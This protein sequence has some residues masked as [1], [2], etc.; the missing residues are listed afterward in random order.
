VN[1]EVDECDQGGHR[2]PSYPILVWDL[3]K[4][5]EAMG[6]KHSFHPTYLAHIGIG[7]PNI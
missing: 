4:G 5:L 1:A 6:V 3:G 7:F 2:G